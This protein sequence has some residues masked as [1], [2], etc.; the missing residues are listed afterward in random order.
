MPNIGLFSYGIIVALFKKGQIYGRPL[1]GW[2][3]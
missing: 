1:G 3:A 2:G